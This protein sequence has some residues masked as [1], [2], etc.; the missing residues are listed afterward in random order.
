MAAERGTLVPWETLIAQSIFNMVSWRGIQPDGSLS[1]DPA[2]WILGEGRP[3][4]IPRFEGQWTLLM[5]PLP[6]QRAWTAGPKFPG[7]Q[8]ECILE[9]ILPQAE[10][11]RIVERMIKARMKE[12]G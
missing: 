9:E 3:S 10:V 11:E 7:L 12:Q 2:T 4:D 5:G 8:A 6:Y 1:A